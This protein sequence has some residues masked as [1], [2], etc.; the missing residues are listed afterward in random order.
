[1]RKHADKT[2]DKQR[3][4]HASKD[5]FQAPTEK[6]DGLDQIKPISPGN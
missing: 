1:V 3:Q 5:D 4:D 6:T 2:A